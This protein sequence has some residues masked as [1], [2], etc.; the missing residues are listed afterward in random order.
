MRKISCWIISFFIL[1]SWG[2]VSIKKDYPDIQEYAFDV[3]HPQQ[4]MEKQ[5]DLFQ[6][7][8]EKFTA[9][10]RYE[11]RGLIYR[12]E[13]SRFE[14]DYYNRFHAFPADL[15]TEGAIKWFAGAQ[16]LQ[17][18][19][20]DLINVKTDFLLQGVLIELYGDF[21]EENNSG[22]VIEIQFTFLNQETLP[23]IVIFQKTY[24]E[25]IP[26]TTTALGALMQGYTDGFQKIFAQLESDIIKNIF[27]VKDN[28]QEK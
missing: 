5:S 16:Q 25:R 11:A 22:A 17:L 15:A 4:N 9:T 23:P 24:S 1:F 18:I 13:E 10:S 26:L 28:G 21:R 19:T 8:I 20:P 7:N 6:I 27:I 2:C 3:A 14:N 12:R